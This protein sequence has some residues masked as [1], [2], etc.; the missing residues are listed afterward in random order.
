[1]QRS[2]MVRHR[3]EELALRLSSGIELDV[4]LLQYPI[5]ISVAPNPV[6]IAPQMI[7]KL[8]YALADNDIVP[9]MLVRNQELF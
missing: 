8:K 5:R 6:D 2:F 7:P 1:M 3:Y 9:L 4:K